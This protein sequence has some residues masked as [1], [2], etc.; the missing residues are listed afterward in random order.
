MDTATE[1]V[2]VVTLSKTASPPVSKT[3]SPAASEPDPPRESAAPQHPSVDS[4]RARRAIDEALRGRAR[5]VLVSARDER[6]FVET[7]FGDAAKQGRVY[8][9]REVRTGPDRGPHFDL[10]H[11]IVDPA[12]PFV[13]MFN[14]LGTATV[15]STE[16]DPELSA[17][18]FKHYPLPGPSENGYAVRRLMGGIAL[19][20]PGMRIERQTLE[21]GQGLIFPQRGGA[22]PVVYDLQAPQDAATANGLF[23]KL[24]V[25]RRETEAMALA[26]NHCF[27]RWQAGVDWHDVPKT[28]SVPLNRG[29]LSD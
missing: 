17:Y 23:L 6:H 18:Y 29:N 24:L 21:V 7:L 14:V 16:L 10:Y 26:A 25:P 19:R 22:L 2:V 13:A 20:Q 8:V 27:S 5:A 3:A 12:F 4:P 15:V 28:E 9:C 1:E 11:P